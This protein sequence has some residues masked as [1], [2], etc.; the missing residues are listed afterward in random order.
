MNE[1]LTVVEQ[2]M[3]EIVSTIEVS[4]KKPLANR[5]NS[6]YEMEA[7]LKETMKTFAGERARDA[8]KTSADV[9]LM[10]DVEGRVNAMVLEVRNALKDGRSIW[11]KTLKRLDENAKEV[12][13]MCDSVR[14]DELKKAGAGAI[15][16]LAKG[17]AVLFALAIIIAVAW[18][19]WGKPLLYTGR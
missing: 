5:R 16:E 15:W 8:Q 7:I 11:E 3:D 12:Q 6:F 9:L 19:I 17:F 1:Y 10:Q 2:R 14:Q 18:Q 4:L 13:A